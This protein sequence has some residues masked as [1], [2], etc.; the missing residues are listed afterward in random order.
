LEPGTAAAGTD[1][2]DADGQL[3]FTGGT[4]G[5]QAILVQVVGDTDAEPDETFTVVLENLSGATVDIADA[6]GIGT[7]VN[8]DLGHS[9]IFSIQGSGGSSPF[10]NQV[11]RTENNVVTGV[12]ADGFALQT[13][14]SRADGVVHTSDGIF[15][16]TGSAPQ[17]DDGGS[18]R[19]VAVGDLVHVQGTVVEYFGLTEFSGGISV[20]CV[21]AGQ[22]LPT[23]VVFGREGPQGDIPSLDPDALYCGAIDG[24]QN[25]FECLEGMLV[26]V[27]QGIVTKGS[28]R[29]SG[30]D[31]G[32]VHIGPHGRRALR[33]PG[34]RFGNTL[35]PGGND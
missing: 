24:Q 14:D 2:V 22:A 9:E 26:S 11:V 25:N 35:E 1:F 31:Y 21:A 33:E 5:S 23:A 28:Q 4:A 15:V 8:D 18:L 13:P 20:E 6:I 16:F 17:C 34:V 32:P 10:A 19:A 30:D 29:L 12:G 7:I 3:T 27:P